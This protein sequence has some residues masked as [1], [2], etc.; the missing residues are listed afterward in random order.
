MFDYFHIRGFPASASTRAWSA[1]IL[2]LL[3]SDGLTGCALSAAYAKCGLHGCPGD[4]AITAAVRALF[5]RHPA[6]EAPNLLS[7]Q[8]LDG[9]VYLGG[10]LDT[11][12]QR[13]LAQSVAAQPPGVVRVVNSIGLANGR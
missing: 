3:L 2:A 11:D 5:D 1:A 10:I 8:T 7:V 6:L 13:Q 4:A 12:M 9:V